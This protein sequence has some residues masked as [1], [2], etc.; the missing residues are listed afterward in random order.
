MCSAKYGWFC[1][2]S[3]LTSCFPGVLLRYFQNDF[4]MV[5]V[6][7]IIAGFSFVVTFHMCRIS[8]VR[9]LYFRIFST[10]FLITFPSP[11]IAGSMNINVPFPLPQIISG[12]L[13]GM[14]DSII[15]LL[16]LCDLFVVI[17]VHPCAS[18]HCLILP[19]FQCICLSVVGHT[20]MSLYVLNFR[21]YWACGHL[22]YCFVRLVT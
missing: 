17:L 21:Q 13:L 11:E 14:V 4:E 9:S 1:I 3:S 20:I 5:P 7:C 12:L 8:A 22:V 18:V 16:Y 19:L 10:L 15:W 2:C 6:T